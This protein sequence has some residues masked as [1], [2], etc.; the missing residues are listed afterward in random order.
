MDT[1]TRKITQKENEYLSS[2]RNS[3]KLKSS[4]LKNAWESI[5]HE[6]TKSEMANRHNTSLP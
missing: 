5:P 4:M 1:F 3:A 2:P 6:T